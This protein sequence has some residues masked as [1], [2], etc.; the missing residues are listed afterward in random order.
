MQRKSLRSPFFVTVPFMIMLAG[1]S[2]EVARNTKTYGV[3]QIEQMCD[4]RPDMLDV[5]PPDHPIRRWCISQFEAGE[6]GRRVVWDCSEPVLQTPAEHWPRTEGYP[7]AIRIS[8]T[9]PSTGLDKWA[10][11]VFE[12]HN[13]QGEKDRVV[14][15]ES[16]L[17]GEIGVSTFAEGWSRSEFDAMHITRT[18]L[19]QHGVRALVVDAD[20]LSLAILE[21]PKDFEEWLVQLDDNPEGIYDPRSKF[22][23]YGRSL[24]QQKKLLQ[25]SQTDLNSGEVLKEHVGRPSQT[26]SPAP[27]R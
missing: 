11:L 26:A 7:A 14:F 15:R 9:Y 21:T 6:N 16:L 20:K 13:I 12:F 8:K 3:R 10:M 4:D 25:A 22:A 18:F 27:A 17:N 24:L 2:D 23:E 5:L 19:E 1:Y